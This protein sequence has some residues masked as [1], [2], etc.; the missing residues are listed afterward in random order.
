MASTDDSGSGKNEKL[1]S[2]A[3]MNT[4]N[5]EFKAERSERMVNQTQETDLSRH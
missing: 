1:P 4:W 3:N 5:V 2:S